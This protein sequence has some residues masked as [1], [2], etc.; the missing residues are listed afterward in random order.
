LEG[1]KGLPVRAP[2]GRVPY[3]KPYLLDIMSSRHRKGQGILL[4]GRKEGQGIFLA[5]GGRDCRTRAF[6]KGSSLG[7][8]LPSGG[9]NKR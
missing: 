4:E 3:L 9:L 8:S 2:L 6:G 5:L 1:R 7:G